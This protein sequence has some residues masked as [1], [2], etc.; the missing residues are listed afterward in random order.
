[1]TDFITA[2]DLEIESSD[3]MHWARI[4]GVWFGLNLDFE[5]DCFESDL[6]GETVEENLLRQANEEI[7]KH[8]GGMDALGSH[9]PMTELEETGGEMARI[10]RNIAAAL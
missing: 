6:A 1:M 8:S 9:Q 7:G 2:A 5:V 10:R 3:D 4:E